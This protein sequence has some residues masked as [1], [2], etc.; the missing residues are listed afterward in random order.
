MKRN[1]LSSFF[2]KYTPFIRSQ[3]MNGLAYKSFLYTWFLSLIISAICFCFLW[4]GVYSSKENGATVNGFS[5]NEMLF[6]YVFI[7]FTQILI[8]SSPSQ[9]SITT[10]V[11]DGTI[12][13]QLIKPL[14]YR[15][16]MLFMSIGNFL[17]NYLLLI[18]PVS[19][20]GIII[21][22]FTGIFII[23]NVLDF[24]LR[25]VLYILFCFIASILYDSI[26]YLFGIC[27][28]YTLADFGM[29][30]LKQ[31]II[32]FLSGTMLPLSFFPDIA[33]KILYYSPFAS[34]GQNPLLILMGKMDYT[35]IL[36]NFGL[37]LLWIVFFEI[38]NKLFFNHAIKHVTIQG[39]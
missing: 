14:S 4:I 15:L 19:I 13:T 25:Y 11:M 23:S 10:Q 8:T 37:I 29:F 28:F 12:S 33:K 32:N 21:F 5:L 26:N 16:T 35:G 9:D 38:I 7:T 18:L 24:I 1:K 31:I 34:L 6:Y 3:M 39:G 22:H 36:F 27:S 30:L 2:R 20:L 17:S